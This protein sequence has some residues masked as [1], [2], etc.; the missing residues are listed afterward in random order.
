MPKIYIIGPLVA[1]ALFAAGFW[2]FKSG[3][4]RR[5]QARIAQVAAAKETKLKADADARRQAIEAALR[6]QEQRKKEREA[7]EARDKAEKDARQ[8]AL[9]ARDKAAREK[10]KLLRQLD[11]AQ[12]EIAVEKEGIARLETIKTAALAEQAFLRDFVK[13]AE[14]NVKTFEGVFA[15]IDSADRARAAAAAAKKTP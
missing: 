6:T 11:R 5:E 10:D 7:K 3:Y 2:Q 15:Q 8:L 12:K 9:D 13:K 4:E 14:A 1:L